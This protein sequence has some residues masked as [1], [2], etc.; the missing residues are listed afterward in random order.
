MGDRS[1]SYRSN[2]DSHGDRNSARS[3]PGRTYASRGRE[4]RPGARSHVRE[5]NIVVEFLSEVATTVRRKSGTRVGAILQINN[6]G[7]QRGI[8]GA[9]AV[10]SQ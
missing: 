1:R 8:V 5:S 2:G 10:L 9:P 7:L 3:H 4:I 6:F